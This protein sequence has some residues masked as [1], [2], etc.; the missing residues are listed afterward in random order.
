MLKIFFLLTLVTPLP[1]LAQDYGEF[2]SINCDSIPSCV[3]KLIDFAL[4]L[5]VPVAV[6]FV[7][8]AGFLFVSSGG[9]EQKLEIAKKTLFWAI[10]GLFVAIGA[11]ALASAF[12]DFFQN[13]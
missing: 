6:V 8:Y 12:Q 4:T 5:A 9:S 10:I 13:L 11:K 1:I 7:M 3:G 2:W